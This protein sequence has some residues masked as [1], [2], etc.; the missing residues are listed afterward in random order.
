MGNKDAMVARLGGEDKYREWMRANARK[1]AL[2]RDPVKRPWGFAKNKELAR[3]Y[4]KVTKRGK[5]A[6]TDDTGEAPIS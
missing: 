2:S 1:A 3:H 6:K 5:R 4:G